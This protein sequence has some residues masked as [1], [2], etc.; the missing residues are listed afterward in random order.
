MKKKNLNPHIISIM[1][2]VIKVVIFM[3]M[4]IMKSLVN[5]M[6]EKEEL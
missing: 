4:I 6:K 1:V 2:A 3:T 5:V